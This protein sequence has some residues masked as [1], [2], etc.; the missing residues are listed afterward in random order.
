VSKLLYEDEILSLAR[1]HGCDR[2]GLDQ[3]RGG[4][5]SLIGKT[6]LGD[7]ALTESEIVL[8]LPDFQI[9]GVQRKQGNLRIAAR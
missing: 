2:A 7:N 9:T 6:I 5:Q 8:G 3:K 1:T 4:P